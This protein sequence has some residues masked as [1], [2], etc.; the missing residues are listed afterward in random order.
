[1][2][3]ISWMRVWYCTSLALYLI[4]TVVQLGLPGLHYD[5]AKEA[6][7][8]AIELLHGLPITA[9][10]DQTLTLFGQSLPLMVQDYIGALNIYLSMPFLAA[11]GVGVPNLRFLPVL[12]GLAT[13]LTLERLISTW[14]FHFGRA[15]FR[16]VMTEVSRVPIS[17][18]GLLA[19]TLLAV[20]PTFIFWSRQ[21]IF[22]TNLTQPLTFLCMWQALYWW[23]GGHGIALHLAVLAA[24]FAL[25]AKLLSI[26]LILPF[27]VIFLLIW[28]LQRRVQPT[29]PVISIRMWITLLLTFLLPLLPFILFNLQSGG[30]WLNV[31][32]NLGQSYYGVS[33]FAVL[34]NAQIRLTQLHQLLT[35]EHFWYLGGIYQNVL[36]PWIAGVLLLVSVVIAAI[37]KRLWLIGL[38]LLLLVCAILFSLVTITDLFITHYALIHPFLIGTIAIALS[39]LTTEYSQK[40]SVVTTGPINKAVSKQAKPQKESITT[41]YQGTFSWGL[42]VILVVLLFWGGGDAVNTVRYHRILANSGGLGDHSDAT[43]HLAY[44]LRY[45]GLGVPIVLDWGLDA[46]IRYLSEGTVRPIEIFGYESTTEPD[47]G[48]VDRL[49]VFLPHTDTVYLLRAPHATV[50]QGRRAAFMETSTNHGYIPSLLQTFSQR[51]GTPLFEVWQLRTVDADDSIQQTAEESADKNTTNE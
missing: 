50:F 38:P 30:T 29:L 11:T 5:E 44:S 40:D 19:I 34:E 45:N 3:K 7:L 43:Y 33:N 9:F 35:G 32:G 37:Q 47:A 12:T 10:R 2:N 21:G 42:V 31:A 46:P 6:G 20:S 25:Y 36:A 51:D 16:G 17:L 4:A 27:G 8:N 1:M 13:L 14:V 24:G 49:H 41:R 28:L 18:P 23:R 22:V 15:N 48:Y 39:I 26:W